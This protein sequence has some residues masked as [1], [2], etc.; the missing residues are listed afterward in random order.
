MAL[1]GDV[2]QLTP[3]GLVAE[4]T[5]KARPGDVELPTRIMSS[6]HAVAL[7]MINVRIF[8]T[9][10]AAA[11]LQL[12]S[13]TN[14]LTSRPEVDAQGDENITRSARKPQTWNPFWLS[15]S[16]LLATS[17]ILVALVTGLLLLLYLARRSDG[18]ALHTRN[19]FSWTYGPTAVLTV[20]VAGWRQLDYYCKALTPWQE[21]RDGHADPQRSVLLDYK[22]PLQIVSF[23]NA[24]KNRHAT[25]AVTILGFI[26]LKLVTLASTGLLLP[27]VISLPISTIEVQQSTR[28]NGALYNETEN[29][30]LF[31]P[32]IAYT[33]FAVMAKGLPYADGTT[34]SM[35]YEQYRLPASDSS[36]NGTVSAQLRALVS[37]YHC[38][39]APVAIKLQPANVTDQHPEDNLE[40]LF[41]QCR[42]RANGGGTPAFVLNPQTFVCPDR[43]L[44]PLLQQIDC[45]DGSDNWQLLTLADLRYKQAIVNASDLVLGDPVAASSW[46]TD[47]NTITSIACRSAFTLNDVDL[48]Y[49][50]AS[51]PPTVPKTRLLG[52]NNSTNLGDFTGFDLGVL[53]TSALSASADMF[54]NLVDNGYVLEYPNSLFKMMAAISGGSYEN[55]LN[56]TVMIQAAERVLQQV[57]L[58][59]I[60]KYMISPDRTELLATLLQ[61]QERLQVSELSAWLM[62]SGCMMIMCFTLSLLWK[63][64]RDVSP[65]N[66]EIL[67][68]TA[69][70]AAHSSEFASL[71]KDVSSG[72][73]RELDVILQGLTFSTQRR[74]AGDKSIFSLV[75]SPEDNDSTVERK[76]TDLNSAPGQIS[77]WSP[78]TLKRPIL[79]MSLALPL[80]AV[81]VLEALQ[82]L[83]DRHHGFTSLSGNDLS[84]TLFTR[85]TPALL[86]LTIATLINSLDFNVAVLAPF[87]TLRDGSGQQSRAVMSTSILGLPL[88]FAL[89]QSLKLRQWGSLLSGSASLV[90]SILTIVVSGLFTVEQLSV[91]QPISLGIADQFNTTWIDSAKNDSSAAV[92]VS[93]TE[94]I[95]LA[96][97]QYTSG[98]LAL[99]AL[100]SSTASG[101]AIESGEI[102]QIGLSTLRGDLEC[103][104]LPNDMVNVSATYNFRI[105]TAQAS[106]S[107]QAPLPAA[108]RLGGVNGTEDVI[109]FSNSFA[110][111]GKSSFVGKLIDLHVGPFD[112]IQ[113]SSFGELSPNTQLDNPPGCPSLA[114]MYGFADVDDPIKTTITTLV[115]YQYIDQVQANV[116]FVLPDL[117]I[118]TNQP[119][120]VDESTSR[121]LKSGSNNETAFQF[122]LQ[123]HMDDEF[124]SFNQTGDG[125][126][127]L[128]ES[129]PPLDNFFRGVLFGKEPLDETLLASTDET[130]VSHV[131]GGIR[132]F[133]RRYMAQAISS[134][135]RVSLDPDQTQ[136]VPGTI[137]NGHLQARIVQN[138]TAKIILQV[139]L[140]LIFVLAS[141]AVYISKL[142]ELV[143]F[144]P[145]TI[146]GVAI[147]FAR[148]RLC[149]L[150]DPLGEEVMRGNGAELSD[151]QYRFKLGWWEIRNDV[152]EQKHKWY[153]IDAEKEEEK[154]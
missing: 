6:D 83:S 26:I 86:M 41:P 130:D 113:D 78:L 3:T 144:N 104:K 91:P 68:S 4:Y 108:C 133:Y 39:S 54:G 61:K 29:Q 85:F 105:E 58:Q 10:N 90:A 124:S 120:I 33:A 73:D 45:Y 75:P 95:G 99:P 145:C 12:A 131:F 101:V 49:D 139:L 38:E 116:S 71:L 92:V 21:L 23:W 103:V 5:L 44:S 64:P 17:S 94:S 15:R 148:S 57:A 74:L 150:V 63:R 40:L 56:E 11:I 59:S 141:L 47:V 118:P 14:Q 123:L 137:L 81:A 151:E 20:F 22:S 119:P 89:W 117:T 7:W 153:G 8:S 87:N 128:A 28:L 143:P 18:L 111:H 152:R 149:D 102:L 107:A 48:S 112:P 36:I 82:Q 134:N 146:A 121:R 127:T 69:R 53:T 84:L 136:P 140:S 34:V 147:L 13:K 122:R 72:A 62:L 109:D 76:S 65:R 70:L 125:T 132:G 25:V 37:K 88:P 67:G 114:F 50:F 9:G 138:R 46:S 60:A 66:V 24:V 142:H 110:L 97:P 79:V 30:G 52:A 19:H 129:S 98:E 80:S 27:S 35:V 77:W 55:L 115:C 154:G 100:R 126:S 2:E 32:S 135:M 16:F 51:S 106:V 43:Q 31:D 93:L 1:T 96:D 42:L